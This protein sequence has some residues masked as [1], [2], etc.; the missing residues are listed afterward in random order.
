MNAKK[1]L[2]YYFVNNIQARKS[3]IESVILAQQRV[4]QQFEELLGDSN[5]HD[6]YLTALFK[7]KIK[8]SKVFSYL[9]DQ[10]KAKIE[11]ADGTFDSESESEDEEDDFD[12]SSED[13]EPTVELEEKCPLGCELSLYNSVL[14]LREKRLDQDD[15]LADIQKSVEVI[16]FT[17]NRS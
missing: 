1:N 11:N 14:E 7:K 4:H 9:T 12:L 15:L 13:E 2:M 10:K 8:R 3:D 6:S 17:N 5:K 16:E